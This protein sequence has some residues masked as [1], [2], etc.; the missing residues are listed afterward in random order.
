ML[1]EQFSGSCYKKAMSVRARIQRD[2]ARLYENYNCIICPTSPTAAFKLGQKI[3]N[4]MAMY[5]SD[6]FTIFV[7]LSRTASISVPA[8]KTSE[9]LPVGVQFAGPM[10]SEARLLSLAQSW[11]ADCAREEK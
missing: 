4:P 3:D 2:I 9:D 8:G 1:S 7:N 10:L 11:H 5:L 6:M